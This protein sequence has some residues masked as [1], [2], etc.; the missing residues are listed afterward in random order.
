MP[1]TLVFLDVY[2]P[3]AFLITIMPIDMT[4]FFITT[5]FPCTFHCSLIISL[6]GQ[7]ELYSLA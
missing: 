6:D 5:C 3:L 4:P 2:F 7:H 1:F